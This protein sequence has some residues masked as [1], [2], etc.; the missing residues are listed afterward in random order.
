MGGI[1]FNSANQNHAN[2]VRWID[3]SYKQVT[4]IA[5]IN[6]LRLIEVTRRLHKANLFG[7]DTLYAGHY[8]DPTT[9]TI[10]IGFKELKEEITKNISTEVNK[11][12]GIKVKFFS[13]CFTLKELEDFQNKILIE[14]KESL[15]EVPITY[16]AT[17]I[18]KNSL[19]VGVR[20]LKTKY[21][22]AISNFLG[23]DA[24]VIFEKGSF[25]P[26]SKTSR[27]RP[28]LLGG[29]QIWTTK[30]NSTLGFRAVHNNGDVGF[31]MTGHAGWVG[32]QV[33]Q[34]NS[35][36]NNLVGSITVNPQ[37]WRRSDAAFVR[38]GPNV[39]I[40]DVIWPN[41]Q[42]VGWLEY[43]FTPVGTWVY[44]EGATR[45]FTRVGTIRRLNVT[46]TDHPD[47]G[48]LLSQVETSFDANTGDSGGPVYIPSSGGNVQILGVIAGRSVDTGGRVYYSPID[49]IWWDLN[50]RWRG[51]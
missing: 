43:C 6:N 17:C 24:P 7:P 38:L 10:Y 41:R 27:Y 26:L 33:F 31:V 16:I 5:L 14:L 35:G 50:L 4:P 28:S 13:A 34:P 11:V 42:V 47:F 9:G 30:G 49:G 48:I 18:F 23:R 44:H 51:K 20:E 1:G 40:N 12:E 8:A 22:D 39:V 3:G 29:I 45:D 36:V 21:T 25:E 15:K 2:L 46:I 32:T 19:I 37:G